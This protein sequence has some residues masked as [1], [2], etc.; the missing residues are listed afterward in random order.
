MATQD[1]AAPETIDVQWL[2]DAYVTT[3]LVSAKD[4]PYVIPSLIP[5]S[6]VIAAGGRQKVKRHELHCSQSSTILRVAIQVFHAGDEISSLLFSAGLVLTL[7]T[8]LC[9]CTS[10]SENQFPCRP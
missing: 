8:G 4:R 2:D 3:R 7:S 9:P 5:L 1:E 6:A 10:S